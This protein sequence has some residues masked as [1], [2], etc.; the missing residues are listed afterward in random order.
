MLPNKS[1]SVSSTEHLSTCKFL[2]NFNSP[3]RLDY[4][5]EPWFMSIP[6]KSS[7]GYDDFLQFK[8]KLESSHG[9]EF[10]ST[11]EEVPPCEN[12]NTKRLAIISA[13]TADNPSLFDSCLGIGC[14]YI[15]L[16]K[17][18]APSLSQLQQMMINAQHGIN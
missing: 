8:K 4:V 17:P 7:P 12:V 9:V 1:S 2:P 6:G 11:V 3:A 14:R 16:E 10:F 5:V 18:G 15:F 13:R